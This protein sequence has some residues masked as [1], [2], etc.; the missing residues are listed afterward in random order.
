MLLSVGSSLQG[1]E[2]DSTCVCVT[3]EKLLYKQSHALELVDLIAKRWTITRLSPCCQFPR[4]TWHCGCSSQDWLMSLLLCELAR[5]GGWFTVWNLS[6]KT[7]AKPLPPCLFQRPPVPAGVMSLCLLCVNRQNTSWFTVASAYCP[8]LTATQ[9]WLQDRASS[10]PFKNKLSAR[11]HR[12]IPIKVLYIF[13]EKI[14]Q[15]KGTRR[16]LWFKDQ[17]NTQIKCI[18]SS[19][20]SWRE[21]FR[22][23]SLWTGVVEKGFLEK[24]VLWITGQS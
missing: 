10:A 15:R 17:Q 8:Q 23:Q 18:L 22:R 19:R 7:P 16:I 13:K 6:S 12:G 2:V 9:W 20:G 5:P 4:A 24:A 14:F 3:A 21:A 11:S 1:T